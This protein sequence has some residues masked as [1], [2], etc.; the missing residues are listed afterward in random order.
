MVWGYHLRVRG[1]RAP[2]VGSNTRAGTWSLPLC[3][4]TDSHRRQLVGLASPAFHPFPGW[5]RLHT[6]SRSGRRRRQGT[7]FPLRERATPGTSDLGAVILS[8]WAGPRRSARCSLRRIARG[9]S[10]TPRGFVARGQGRSA[11]LLPGGVVGEEPDRPYRELAGGGRSRP[12]SGSGSA[13][14]ARRRSTST[15]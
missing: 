9:R 3:R 14:T 6:T 13:R 8:S 15:R 10:F 5:V 1:F 4:R 2:R 12:S 7:V 11:G